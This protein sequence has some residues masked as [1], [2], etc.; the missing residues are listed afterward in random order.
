M[1]EPNHRLPSDRRVASWKQNQAP[2]ELLFCKILKAG[3]KPLKCAN[4]NDHKVIDSC[5]HSLKNE[6]KRVE[7]SSQLTDKHD[8][9]MIAWTMNNFTNPLP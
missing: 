7:E 6:S 8:N 9:N 3:F 1:R 5:I 4:C 2:R